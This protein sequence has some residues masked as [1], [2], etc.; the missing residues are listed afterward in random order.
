M[1]ISPP[2]ERAPSYPVL[3]CFSAAAIS[4]QTCLSWNVLNWTCFENNTL[5]NFILHRVFLAALRSLP[6]QTLIFTSITYGTN[7]SKIKIWPRSLTCRFSLRRMAYQ[8][9]S[10][11][12][13][14][15]PQRS[16]TLRG[17]SSTNP[18]TT[19]AVSDISFQPYFATTSSPVQRLLN[20]IQGSLECF[21]LD[22]N[23]WTGKSP[24]SSTVIS[25]AS[26]QRSTGP[27]RSEPTTETSP[28]FS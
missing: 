6:L 2:Y 22:I 12:L 23:A 24:F 5:H 13:S 3:F 1:M 16:A 7:N 9:W 15:G 28:L 20:A 26:F 8:R 4:I 19:S 17:C 21:T 14:L 25:L 18:C 11:Y 27:F 10:L